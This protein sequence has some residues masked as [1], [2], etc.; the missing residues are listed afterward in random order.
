MGFSGFCDCTIRLI[1][2]Y[3][4]HYMVLNGVID[5]IR[6]KTISINFLENNFHI[7]YKNIKL[8]SLAQCITHFFLLHS[9]LILYKKEHKLCFAKYAVRGI[10]FAHCT[11]IKQ[12][13]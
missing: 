5:Y 9:K 7:A 10:S 3:V 2:V 8:R 4:S 1:K 6:T 13:T 11:I 12:Y